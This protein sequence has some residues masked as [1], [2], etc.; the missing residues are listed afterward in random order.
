LVV[1]GADP[2]IAGEELALVASIGAQV[3]DLI[4]A[5][6]NSGYLFDLRDV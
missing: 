3:Q 1:V 5:V 4:T 6:Q 2:P